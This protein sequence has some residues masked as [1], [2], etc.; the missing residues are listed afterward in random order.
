[1]K[2]KWLVAIGLMLVGFML[3]AYGFGAPSPTTPTIPIEPEEQTE[4]LPQEE[5]TGEGGSTT[6]GE[7]PIY[8]PGLPPWF[9]HPIDWPWFPWLN[10]QP[11]PEEPETTEKLAFCLQVVR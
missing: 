2:I 9:L 6:S 8:Q 7:L 1:M 11:T 4:T 3:V 10:P 5:G